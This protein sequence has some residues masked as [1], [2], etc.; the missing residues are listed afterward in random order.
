MNKAPTDIK[1][2]ITG[3]VLL[4]G[5]DKSKYNGTL[6]QVKNVNDGTQVGYYVVTP[7][8]SSGGKSI[9]ATGAKTCLLDSGS[10]QDTLPFDYSKPAEEASFL[11]A[12]GIKNDDG[13]PY[14]YPTTCDKI[15]AGK[16]IDYTFPGSKA[17]TSVTVKVPLRNYAKEDL[18]YPGFEKKCFLSID[19]IGCTFGAPFFT[20]AF[21]AANDDI[22]YLALAQGG[23]APSNAGLGTVVE[24]A[25]NA[26][27]K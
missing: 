10:L 12:T 8:L 11:N 9:K 23:V 3:G 18:Q 14:Y 27:P 19:V 24:I 26:V 6:T 25:K 17:G 7:S 4:G 5:I 20:A 15:P 21:L 1:A 2:T 13:G 22:N 16:T